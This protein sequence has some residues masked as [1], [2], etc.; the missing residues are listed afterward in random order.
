MKKTIFSAICATAML[1][2][3]TSVLADAKP[4]PSKPAS[5]QQIANKFVGHMQVWK[6]CKGGIYFGGNWE[7]TAYCD[8][9]KKSVAVGKWTS[10]GGK[11]CYDVNW[12]FVK[13]NKLT[14]KNRAK[15]ELEFVTDKDGQLWHRWGDDKD[16]WRG[17][18]KD[19]SFPKGN[20]YKRQT[21]TQRGKLGI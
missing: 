10:K 8:Q 18:P 14:T 6:S 21:A 12:Y 3:A 5:A 19:K 1:F 13:D 9:N 2:G 15:C 4:R 17:F 16:W 7:A 11:L 20:K